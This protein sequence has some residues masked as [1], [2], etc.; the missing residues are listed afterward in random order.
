MKDDLK[1]L[2]IED[3]LNFLNGRR[4]H[5]FKMEDDLIITKW[6]TSSIFLKIED[7]LIFFIWKIL[8]SICLRM[9]DDLKKIYLYIYNQLQSTVHTSR[10]PDQQNKLK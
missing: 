5:S 4:P 6:K 8:T 7:N 1:Y 3:D 9:E 10:Q 2:K